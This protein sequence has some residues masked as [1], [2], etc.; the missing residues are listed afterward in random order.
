MK[1]K[2]FVIVIIAIATMGAF[3]AL[4]MSGQTDHIK[5]SIQDAYASVNGFNDV[6]YKGHT[7]QEYEVTVTKLSDDDYLLE[8]TMPEEVKESSDGVSF[9][10]IKYEIHMDRWDSEME[11]RA[12]TGRL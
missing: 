1:K 10:G 6:V 9:W 5:T 3:V 7:D 4:I 2:F 11:S 8:M 12:H